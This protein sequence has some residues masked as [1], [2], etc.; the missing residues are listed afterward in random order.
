MSATGWRLFFL[1]D[2]DVHTGDA[3]VVDGHTY[4][5]T[6]EPWEARNPLTQTVSHIEASV[7]R[8]AGT[9]ETGS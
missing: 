5:L 8:V 2:V 9:E 4:E 3:I 6:G 1:P 7:E